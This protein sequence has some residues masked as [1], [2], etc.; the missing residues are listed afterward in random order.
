MFTPPIFYLFLSLNPFLL[1]EPV[2]NYTV[3]LVCIDPYPSFFY[4]L[5]SPILKQVRVVLLHYSAIK[6][7]GAFDVIIPICQTK[8]AKKKGAGSAGDL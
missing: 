7:I 2:F 4:L 8:A 1:I 3:S 5:T 6:G